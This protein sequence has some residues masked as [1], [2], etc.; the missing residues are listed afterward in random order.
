MEEPLKLLSDNIFVIKFILT[1]KILLYGKANASIQGFIA[2][3]VNR[4]GLF[5]IN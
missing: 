5:I 3:S 2:H 4:D 1:F